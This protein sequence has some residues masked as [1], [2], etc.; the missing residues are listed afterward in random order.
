[1]WKFSMSCFNG[2]AE[3]QYFLYA[4]ND[5]ENSSKIMESHAF[6]IIKLIVRMVFCFC[7]TNWNIFQDLNTCKISYKESSFR[8][9]KC[10]KYLFSISHEE[11]LCNLRIWFHFTIC[12]FFQFKSDQI[13]VSENRDRIF[14]TNLHT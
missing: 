9:S 6:L 13:D 7:F 14:H 3:N 2:V 1:M 11:C 10:N 12:I 8:Y 4:T 5:C